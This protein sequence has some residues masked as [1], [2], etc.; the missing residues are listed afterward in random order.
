[1]TMGPLGPS[2]T[3]VNT[4]KHGFQYDGIWNK[5]VSRN[6]PRLKHNVVLDMY[7][8]LAWGAKFQLLQ[9]FRPLLGLLCNPPKHFGYSRTSNS[10]HNDNSHCTS[11]LAKLVINKHRYE[12]IRFSVFGAVNVLIAIFWVLTIQHE[13]EEEVLR[14]FSDVL[15]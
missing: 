7:C 4:P 15:K 11:N 9:A 14:C 5:N 8:V 1:M 6:V 12:N 3:G 2:G 13:P 10:N